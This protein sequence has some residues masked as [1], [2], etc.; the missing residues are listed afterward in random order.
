M[1]TMIK[2]SLVLATYA[3]VACVGLALVYEIT[4]P[5]IAEAAANEVKAGLRT[6]FPDVTDFDDVTGAVSSGVDGIVF[7][8]AYVA[9]T[10]S[11]VSGMVIQATG[12]TYK[13]STLLVAVNMA[14]QIIA[15][16]FTANTDT[17]GL[18]S[19]TAESP[20]IDQFRAKS[21]DDAFKAGSDV[22]A[23]SGATISSKA[24]AT[25]LKVAG[26]RA[27]EYLAANYG[28]PSGSGSAGRPWMRS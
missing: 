10:G 19:K 24:V 12:P 18:G 17:P 22:Q 2:L 4:A 23:I 13:S 26:F 14:R 6:V 1:K 27:G 15:V 11:S 16:R 3:A 7:D 5:R 21:V 20:F 28:A 25:I 9:K 8:R